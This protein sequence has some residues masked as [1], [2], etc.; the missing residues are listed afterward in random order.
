MS[1]PPIRRPKS[2]GAITKPVVILLLVVC[3]VI[4]VQLGSARWRFRREILQLQGLGLGLAIGFVIGRMG[5]KGTHPG[6]D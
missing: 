2:E 1:P 4:G 3:L 6:R 5:R